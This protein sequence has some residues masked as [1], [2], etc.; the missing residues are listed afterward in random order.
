MLD[1]LIDAFKEAMFRPINK[2]ASAIL[3]VFSILW[4][5]WL[6][7]PLWSVFYHQ[8]VYEVMQI[9][10]EEVWGGLAMIVGLG[11]LFG[12][13]NGRFKMLKWSVLSGFY[14]W[15]F[16]AI[17]S[18]AGHWSDPAGVTMLMVAAYSGYV[19]LNLSINEDYF[20]EQ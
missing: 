5:F 9:L 6:A 7:N 3:G 17:A 8:E 19:A 10:P 4:G 14:F 16:V 13:K 18:L 20:I 12:Q 1:S 2:S 15:L 11:M